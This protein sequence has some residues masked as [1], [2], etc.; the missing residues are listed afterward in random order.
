MRLV[1]DG[2][3]SCWQ[4][5]RPSTRRTTGGFI[6]SSG[7]LWYEIWHRQNERGEENACLIAPFQHRTTWSH[8]KTAIELI[9]NQLSGKLFVSQ[10]RRRVNCRGF[11]YFHKF[12]RKVQD[13]KHSGS[14]S[15]PSDW[16]R[17]WER[18]RQR[19]Q[20]CSSRLK[21]LSKSCFFLCASV[22]WVS[23]QSFAC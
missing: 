4:I 21:L 5:K 10:R 3:L 11:S 13:A 23:V 15:T 7:C 16:H 19:K 1:G 9:W 20:R 2:N 18:T 14:C 17:H 6:L 22:L 12:K 8:L